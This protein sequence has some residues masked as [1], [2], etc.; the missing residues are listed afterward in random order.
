VL[1]F[2]GLDLMSDWTDGGLEDGR[3]RIFLDDNTQAALIG[4]F[5]PDAYGLLR[6]LASVAPHLK[7]NCRNTEQVVDHV[8][9][10][11]G[12]DIGVPTIADGPGVTLEMVPNAEASSRML[13]AHLERLR[14]DGVPDAEIT[15]LSPTPD[16][17]CAALL[18]STIRARIARLTPSAVSS[19]RTTI[20]LASP[21]EFKG[22]ESNFVFLVD[23]HQFGG[24]SRVTDE[25]YVA[26]TRARAALWIAMDERLRADVDNAIRTHLTGEASH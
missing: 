2:E 5:D 22:L 19:E 13:G 6:G 17:S 26:M 14:K 10:L 25:L 20:A 9:M 23:V 15:I 11:T 21:T 18:K 16:E 1:D 3:W 7:R 12:A 4:R 8:Q 24:D